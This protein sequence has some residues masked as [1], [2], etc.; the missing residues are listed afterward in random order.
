MD[1]REWTETPLG[2]ETE[3]EGAGAEPTEE[4]HRTDPLMVGEEGPWEVNEGSAADHQSRGRIQKG[5]EEVRLRRSARGTTGIEELHN[6]AAEEGV[7][8]EEAVPGVLIEEG[9]DPA[10]I[11]IVVG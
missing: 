6:R 2:S 10:G 8:A 7:V 1:A 3:E 9:A 4:D 11:R 5:V